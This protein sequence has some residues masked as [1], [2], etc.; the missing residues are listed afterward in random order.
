MLS[1]AEKK[2]IRE[3]WQ[4]VQ[5]VIETAADLFYRR[6]AEQHPALRAQS[7]EQLIAQRNEFVTTLD[8]VARGLAW[9]AHEWRDQASDEDDLFLGMVALGQR[10]SR[11]ARLFE[12]HYSEAGESLLW[13]FTYALGKRF[14]APARAAW[15]RLYTLLA[16]AVRLGRLASLETGR[17]GGARRPPPSE[18]V[19]RQTA[20]PEAAREREAPSPAPQPRPHAREAKPPR[21]PV[22]ERRVTLRAESTP[23]GHGFRGANR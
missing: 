10:G 11:L 2:A 7:P 20:H 13:T 21:P 18:R 1:D 19:V 3:S 6:L 23:I 5:P 8:F 16:N 17:P 22:R 12:E 4:Q 9:D 15:M 14:D